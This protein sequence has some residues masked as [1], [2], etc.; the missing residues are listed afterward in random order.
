MGSALAN[1]CRYLRIPP[2][3]HPDHIQACSQDNVYEI[4]IICIFI[5]FQ[6]VEA[7]QVVRFFRLR[8]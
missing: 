3:T 6:D 2:Q 1:G 7:Q 8:C 4:F 5:V